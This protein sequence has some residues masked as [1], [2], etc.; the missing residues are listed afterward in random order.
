MSQHRLVI[1]MEADVAFTDKE[2]EIL[3]K[4]FKHH[5][6]FDVS[7]A[8]EHGGWFY[9]MSSIRE[10]EKSEEMPISA[11]QLTFRQIDLM[12]KAL[13]MDRSDEAINLYRRLSSILTDMNGTTARLSLGLDEWEI[14]NSE[15][16]TTGKI[17]VHIEEPQSYYRI[18]KMIGS[19]VW[20][21]KPE[22]RLYASELHKWK[23]KTT[24][25]EGNKKQVPDTVL[26]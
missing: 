16:V 4:N 21:L 22:R 8:A 25:D 7:S 19:G 5:Y 12:T 20:M 1:R 3:T 2:F 6:S 11:R 18:E 10:W 13:E 23:T 26:D 24:A 17:I 15:N 9:G 14:L